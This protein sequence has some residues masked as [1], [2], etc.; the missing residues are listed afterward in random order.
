MP[1]NGDL[2]IIAMAKKLSPE[3]S[4][5]LDC[6]L[7]SITILVDPGIQSIPK[8]SM[9]KKIQWL[10][11]PISQQA[12]ELLMPRTPMV[13]AKSITHHASSKLSSKNTEDITHV[14]W[15]DPDLVC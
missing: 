6:I 3:P 13:I 12:Y 4:S 14:A 2:A 5:K 9:I 7:L 11:P 15:I 10:L 1:S 8:C